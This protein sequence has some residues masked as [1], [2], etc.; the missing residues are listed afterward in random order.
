MTEKTEKFP[1]NKQLKKKAGW[2]EKPIGGAITR[3]ASAL[4]NKTGSWKSFRPVIDEKKCIHCGMC[5]AYCPDNAI[6][7][8]NGKRGKV[9]L[10][11]CKGCGICSSVCPVKAIEMKEES[12]FED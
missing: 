10:D 1:T 11:Y 2:K 6:P 7:F 4:E 5:T 8:K 3:T 12:E 9:N